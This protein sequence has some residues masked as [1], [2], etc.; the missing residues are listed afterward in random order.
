MRVVAILL[1]L[2]LGL[3]APAAGADPLVRTFN[4]PMDRVWTV[5]ESVLK[6]LG[7]D[8]DNADRAV[9]FITTESRSLDGEDYGPGI[10]AMFLGSR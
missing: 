4:A 2:S 8:I 3:A 6:H 7:W 9:G 10:D 1:A 5:T